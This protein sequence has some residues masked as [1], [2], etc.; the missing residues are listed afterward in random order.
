VLSLCNLPKAVEAVIEATSKPLQ[1]LDLSSKTQRGIS[2]SDINLFEEDIRL[3]MQ[4][5]GFVFRNWVGEEKRNHG[6]WSHCNE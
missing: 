6:L 5:I 3:V 2:L 1:F 4:N